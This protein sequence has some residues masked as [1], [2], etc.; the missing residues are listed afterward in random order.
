MTSDNNR[1]TG[2]LARRSSSARDAQRRLEA[3]MRH[4]PVILFALDKQGVLTL[5][6]GRELDRA[7]TQPMS[8]IGKSVPEIAAA[9]DMP[10]IIDGFNR[11]MRGESIE[12]VMQ[13]GDR[14]F[15]TRAN[16]LYS[17]ANEIEGVLGVT[18]DITERKNSEEA[19]TASENRYR[20]MIDNIEDGYYE[21][22]LAG[23]FTLVNDGLCR[24]LNVDRDT[25][26]RG[27]HRSFR[28]FTDEVNKESA[29][30][31]FN[32]VFRT[33]TPI[34]ALEGKAIQRGGTEIYVELSISL[35]RGRHGEP[36]GFRGIVR[37]VSKR[38]EVEEALAQRMVLLSV[39]QQM[40]N[41]LNQTLELDKVLV[42][43][44]KSA[45]LLSNATTGF[46]GLLENDRLKLVRV[47][48]ESA[49]YEAD[50]PVEHGI[51]GRA[52]R[53]RQPLLV[54][55]V[56]KDPDY[57]ADNA[58]TRAEIAV[59][60]IT[61]NKVLGVMNLEINRDGVFNE[62]VLEYMVMLS[63]RTGEAI[64]NARLY[65]LSQ[66][67]LGE[68]RGLYSHMSELEQLKTDMIR[69]ASH[70]LRSPLG[71]I[72][73]YL[74]ILTFDLDPVLNEEQRE[75][76]DAMRRAAERIQRMSTE[77]LSLERVNA[78]RNQPR[79]PVS[80]NDLALRSLMDHRDSARQKEVSLIT[81]IE[82]H[83]TFLVMADITSLPE[84]I[85]NLI[86]N[87]IKYTASGGFVTV[88]LRSADEAGK[89]LFEVSDTGI[90][91]RAEAQTR[92]FEPFYRVKSEETARIDGTGLGLY[93]VKRIIEQHDGAMRF[94]STYGQGSTFGFT[95]PLHAKVDSNEPRTQETSV[96]Q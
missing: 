32:A 77:I 74:D 93:L 38:K 18:F 25:L 40:D 4:V 81:D 57:I 22:S 46:I 91:I 34:A 52:I 27:D 31:H 51:V 80:L 68:L 36:V 78:L 30:R 90:G 92:L 66:E 37:D 59:P 61:H 63:A 69:I 70:D 2:S 14:W 67:Q 71:I 17:T 88:R 9:L 54:L 75:Y 5:I 45:M 26:L 55:D 1:Q 76:F 29:E 96:S 85:D 42:V 7:V 12:L 11:V 35:M 41:E 43:A 48:G 53:L 23:E 87:A 84:A 15:E 62:S 3:I 60:L 79:A 28:V 65:Q 58:D 50:L 44:L 10:K 13:I 56:S 47:A 64:E 83:T 72:V 8:M 6:E 82:P 24:I 20:A 95:M 39:L 73:G 16:P 94:S 49:Q 86:S 33:G 21:V 19:L 89:V